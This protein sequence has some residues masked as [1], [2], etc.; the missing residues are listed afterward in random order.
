MINSVGTFLAL[1]LSGCVPIAHAFLVQGEKGVQRFPLLH[2]MAMGQCYL[3]GTFFYLTHWPEERWPAT[4]DIWV[5]RAPHFSEPSVGELTDCM[6][7]VQA[8]RS[9]MS[10]LHLASLCFI[11]GFWKSCIYE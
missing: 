5:R 2:I 10:W 4:F 7:R 11:E 1:M 9:F 6:S 3:V 8:I